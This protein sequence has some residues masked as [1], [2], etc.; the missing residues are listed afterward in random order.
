MNR[1]L[2]ATMFYKALARVS[3][4]RMSSETKDSLRDFA[5]F[6]IQ[7]TALQYNFF[8]N[9]I[10]MQFWHKS[11]GILDMDMKASLFFSLLP[12]T[13]SNLFFQQPLGL[14]WKV[15]AE[16]GKTPEFLASGGEDFN[17]GPVMRLDHSQ[18]LC[19]K[20]LLKYKRDRESFWHRHPKGAEKIPPC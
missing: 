19:N 13:M 4:L 20:V 3:V 11:F 16:P 18:L 17:P 5:L 6:I 8:C 1:A 15:V 10:S 9:K 7:N 14:Y 2:F 12:E